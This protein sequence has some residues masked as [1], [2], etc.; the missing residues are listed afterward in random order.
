MERAPTAPTSQPPAVTTPQRGRP[1]PPEPKRPQAAAPPDNDVDMTAPPSP[2]K[3]P[4]NQGTGKVLF[5]GDNQ[6]QGNA[7]PPSP[8]APPPTQ[9][10]PMGGGSSAATP[11]AATPTISAPLGG[12]HLTQQSILGAFAPSN[13]QPSQTAR[14]YAQAA[15]GHK[16]KDPAQ[17]A[18]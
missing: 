16:G 6:N 14:T 1:K 15:H 4:Q 11:M 2:S 13:Q 17:Q 18:Q 7:L 8:S 5:P 12:G 10:L 3:L 9:G